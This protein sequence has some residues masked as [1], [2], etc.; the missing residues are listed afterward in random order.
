M[1]DSL[2]NITVDSESWIDLY[3]ASGITV[4]NQLVVQNVGQTRILL[5]TGA[6][7]PDD[8]VGFNVLPVNS[9]PYVNQENSTG[10]WAK[11]VDAD[12]SV[13]VGEAG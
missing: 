13:N 2:P 1:A 12:G 3:D 11:S 4:G 7:A 10:E 5:H 6:S 8:T 9:I